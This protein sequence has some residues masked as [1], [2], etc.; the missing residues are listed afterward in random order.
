[1]KHIPKKG[2]APS[3]LISRTMMMSAGTRGRYMANTSLSTIR[4]DFLQLHCTKFVSIYSGSDQEFSI[5]GLRNTHVN[6]SKERNHE[7]R[8]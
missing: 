2:W 4:E 8:Q 3:V 7:Q 1:M 5:S 6:F